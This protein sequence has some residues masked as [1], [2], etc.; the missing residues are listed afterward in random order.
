MTT[1]RPVT[2]PIVRGDDGALYVPADHVSAL[3]RRV[4]DQWSTSEAEDGESVAARAVAEALQDLA[5]QIDVECI[6]HRTTP[7]EGDR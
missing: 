1:G 6:A 3:L 2:L 5:D 7:R 4:A